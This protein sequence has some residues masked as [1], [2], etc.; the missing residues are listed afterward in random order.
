MSRTITTA[1]PSATRDEV[2]R[3]L[4]PTLDEWWCGVHVDWH[5]TDDEGGALPCC[6]AERQSQGR[7][8][9]DALLARFNITPKED[10]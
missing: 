9:A 2:A 6:V 4:V 7:R 8:Q 10:R 1:A 3:A 5:T